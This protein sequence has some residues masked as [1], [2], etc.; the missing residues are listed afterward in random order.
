MSAV[1]TASGTL[2]PAP[3]E[4]ARKLD[5]GVKMSH[6]PVIRVSPGD[7]QWVR[8]LEQAEGLGGRIE[9]F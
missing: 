7:G 8:E 4:P 9:I 6:R 3:P 1:L 2:P 5:G